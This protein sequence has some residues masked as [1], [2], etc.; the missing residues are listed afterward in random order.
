MSELDSQTKGLQSCLENGFFAVTAVAA[1]AGPPAEVLAIFIVQTALNVISP[2]T[3]PEAHL[4]A[5]HVGLYV[6][7]QIAH[8]CIAHYGPRP[9]ANL[10]LHHSILHPKD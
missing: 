3:F 1:I 6:I 7:A 9:F 5:N 4:T 8:M 2:T 10:I